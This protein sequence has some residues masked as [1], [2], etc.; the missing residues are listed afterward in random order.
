MLSETL[1]WSGLRLRGW[2]GR[3]DSLAGAVV[4]GWVF[5]PHVPPP[6][7]EVRLNQRIVA[8]ARAVELRPD[9]AEAGHGDGRC[10]FVIPMV[11]TNE[12]LEHASLSVHVVISGRPMLPGGLIAAGALSRAVRLDALAELHDQFR[13]ES[14]VIRA[15]LARL[16]RRISALENKKGVE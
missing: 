14:A 7:V 6:L 9:V 3:V 4:K 1:A 12:D 13:G 16:R 10:G 11:F 15:D 8:T 5:R 2:R